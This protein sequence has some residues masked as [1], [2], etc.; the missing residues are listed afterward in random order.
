MM[1]ADYRRELDGGLVLKDVG[2]SAHLQVAP[3][4]VVIPASN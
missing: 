3:T 4:S 1:V 2:V